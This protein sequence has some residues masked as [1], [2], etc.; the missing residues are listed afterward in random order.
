MLQLRTELWGGQEWRF[1]D[2][3]DS[4]LPHWSDDISQLGIGCWL[5]LAIEEWVGVHI[6]Q[7]V[8]VGQ[9][10]YGN[11][12]S[13]VTTYINATRFNSIC[14][15]LG[16]EHCQREWKNMVETSRQFKEDDS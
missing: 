3:D 1:G 6:S 13:K 15:P 2:I 4:V 14:R 10:K 12:G 8:L 16:A 5:E 7:E 9:Y 11:E